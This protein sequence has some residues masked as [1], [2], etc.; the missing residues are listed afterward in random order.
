MHG[1]R[2]QGPVRVGGSRMAL[3][4]VEPGSGGRVN[5][6]AE[7]LAWGWEWEHSVRR[8]FSVTSRRARG[9]KW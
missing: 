7:T 6:C 4:G 3:L 2:L 8:G 1:V 9:E 5:G